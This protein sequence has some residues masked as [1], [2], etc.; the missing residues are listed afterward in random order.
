MGDRA[1]RSVTANQF[2]FDRSILY[3]SLSKSLEFHMTSLDI[4]RRAGYVWPNSP[5]EL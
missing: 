3:K 5:D 1:R 2:G 4:M